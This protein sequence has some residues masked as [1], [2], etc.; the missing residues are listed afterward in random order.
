MAQMP[1]KV[2]A[3]DTLSATWMNQVVDKLKEVDDMQK[4][5]RL[6]RGVGYTVSESPGG[7]SLTID[8]QEINRILTDGLSTM[9]NADFQIR[10]KPKGLCKVEE[11]S[12]NWDKI[13]QVHKGYITNHVDINIEV[14]S[15]AKDESEKEEETTTDPEEETGSAWDAS[16]W[17]EM[18]TLPALGGD[19]TSAT[20]GGDGTSSSDSKDSNDTSEK[21][22][23]I[24]VRMEAAGGV[25]VRAEFVAVKDDEELDTQGGAYF[26]PI[27]E[28][29]GEQV[30]GTPRYYIRQH[31]IGSIELG[32]SGAQMPFDVSLFMKL[33]ED[34]KESEGEASGDESEEEEPEPEPH[35]TVRGGRVFMAE[36]QYA[37]I[38]DKEEW[39][40]GT[41]NSL[42][43][44]ITLTLSRDGN[45]NV[46]YKYAVEDLSA[47]GYQ[48]HALEEQETTT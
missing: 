1:Y 6:L 9:H 3:G 29:S 33:P 43:A 2:K 45:G 21:S 36:R 32:G 15:K 5:R 48:I 40:I 7:T 12:G 34:Q 30:D 39:P 37:D 20:D 44:F 46:Y 42:P 19:S 16:E 47:F 13:V 8:K 26:I 10:I 41:N 35:V 38:P 25:P 24:Y 31:Q 28:V 17:V 23:R 22:I 27:G 18:G 14:S 4:R 11:E